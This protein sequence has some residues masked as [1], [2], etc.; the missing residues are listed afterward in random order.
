MKEESKIETLCKAFWVFH[1]EKVNPEGKKKEEGRVREKT[2]RQADR[3]KEGERG[4]RQTD[5]L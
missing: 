5:M 3:K 1:Y 4:D 2:D